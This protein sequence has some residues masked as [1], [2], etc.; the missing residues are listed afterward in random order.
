M[1]K[2]NINEETGDPITLHQ[3]KGTWTLKKHIKNQ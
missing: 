3:I 1:M 2:D